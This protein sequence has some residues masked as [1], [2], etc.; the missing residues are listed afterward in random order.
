M[1]TDQHSYLSSITTQGYNSDNEST[2]Q[3]Q[4][5]PAELVLQSVGRV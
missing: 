4:S 3:Q 5:C 2:A 1:K